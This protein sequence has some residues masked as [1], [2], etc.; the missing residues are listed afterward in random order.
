[1]VQPFK[2]F[3]F[4]HSSFS[5]ILNISWYWALVETL[6][7][8]YH[9]RFFIFGLIPFPDGIATLKAGNTINFPC[10]SPLLLP[11]NVPLRCPRR[12][13]TLCLQSLGFLFV[14]HVSGLDWSTLIWTYGLGMRVHFQIPSCVIPIPCSFQSVE[15]ISYVSSSK[16]ELWHEMI[17][18]AWKPDIK[19]MYKG[20]WEIL[21]FTSSCDFL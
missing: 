16:C 6:G 7:L 13:F 15:F 8:N 4:L 2:H 9:T 10:L 21:K 5:F 3:N 17:Y 11:R 1:M 20:P 19:I 14:S 18:P 12:T